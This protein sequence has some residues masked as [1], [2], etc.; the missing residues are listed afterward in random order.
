[1]SM[2]ITVVIPAYNASHTIARALDSVAQQTLRPCTV[3]VVNDGSTDASVDIV[4]QHPLCSVLPVRVITTPNAG[5][6]AARNTGIRAAKTTHIALLDADDAFH[7]E[8]LAVAA[9]AFRVRPAAIVHWA[10]IERVFDNDSALC[11]AEADTLPDFNAL[12]MKHAAQDLGEQHHLIGQSV[13]AD[14]I[15]GNFI[16]SAVFQREKDGRLNLFNDQ[17]HFA[18]DRLFYLEMLGKGEGL[19]TNRCTMSI[20]RHGGNASVTSDRSRSL[21]INQKV[22]K[23]LDAARHMD[24][25]T[26]D[27][28]RME[29]LRT[30]IDTALRERIYY[31]SFDGLAPTWSAIRLASGSPDFNRSNRALFLLKNLVRAGTAQVRSAR[32]GLRRSPVHSAAG[33]ARPPG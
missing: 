25:I 30:C 22:L 12:S 28:Q 14:L 20:H 18:E 33:S 27:Q 17:L 7:P 4:Q 29:L 32:A 8:H 10:G 16:C 26:R 15:R 9:S 5:V 31:A 24:A 23:A 3:L 11:Q 6:A 1:M 2:S 13:F 19:F 21:A